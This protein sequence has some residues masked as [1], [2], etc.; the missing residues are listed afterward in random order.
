MYDKI[1]NA[2]KTL[3]NIPGPHLTKTQ[4]DIDYLKAIEELKK[5]HKNFSGKKTINFKL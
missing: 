2:R 5:T 4:E 3:E 1:R